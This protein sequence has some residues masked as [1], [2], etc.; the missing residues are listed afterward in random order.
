MVSQHQS[1]IPSHRHRVCLAETV[2]S[3]TVIFISDG[4]SVTGEGTQRGQSSVVSIT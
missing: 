4:E 3:G 1:M 2:I